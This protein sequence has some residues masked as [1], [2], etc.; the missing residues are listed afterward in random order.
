M[1]GSNVV[2]LK[3]T[4]AMV[5]ALSH[6][7]SSFGYKLGGISGRAVWPFIKLFVLDTGAALV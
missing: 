1:R 7:L 6:I 2:K 5:S 3:H 4:R